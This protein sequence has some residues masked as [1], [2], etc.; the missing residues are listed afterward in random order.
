MKNL[1]LFYLQPN[2]PQV[3]K[4]FSNSTLFNG[5]LQFFKDGFA[6][7]KAILISVAVKLKWNEL[8]QAVQDHI[9]SLNWGYRVQLRDMNVTYVNSLGKFVDDH[10]I[11]VSIF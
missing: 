5:V 7:P 1:Y 10:T 11:V 2:L 9:G 4:A 6:F 8:V 3:K